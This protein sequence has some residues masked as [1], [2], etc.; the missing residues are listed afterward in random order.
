MNDC[1][2]V[3]FN[4]SPTCGVSDFTR[5]LCDAVTAVNK[6]VSFVN[7]DSLSAWHVG[8]IADNYKSLLFN[9][10]SVN[11]GRSLFPLLFLILC[12]LRRI[13]IILYVHEFHHAHILRRLFIWAMALVANEVIFANE[14]DEESM[15][16]CGVQK[17]HNDSVIGIFPNIPKCLDHASWEERTNKKEVIISTFGLI[18]DN[19]RVNKFLTLIQMF[20]HYQEVRFWIIGACSDKQYAM[21]LKRKCAIYDNVEIFYDRSA[22]EVACL[23]HRSDA[24]YLYYPDGV[25]ERRGSFFAALNNDCVVFSNVSAV[26]PTDFAKIVYAIDANTIED[27]INT[28]SYYRSSVNSQCYRKVRDRYSQKVVTSRVNEIITRIC[29][30]LERS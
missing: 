3:L 15:R 22:D 30:S 20:S 5:L 1:C 7:Y 26:T 27:F 25:T 23:L 8:D 29:L 11:C 18:S 13:V 17:I 12:R 21:K 6:R 9:Y 4:K 19:D 14:V 16:R 2:F 28:P 10:P 24:V